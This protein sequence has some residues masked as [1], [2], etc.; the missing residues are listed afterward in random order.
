MVMDESHADPPP[1]TGIG[2]AASP[3]NKEVSDVGRVGAIS[4]ALLLVVLAV[5]LILLVVS[6]WPTEIETTNAYFAVHRI[7]GNSVHLSF[8]ADIVLIT[9]FMGGLGAVIHSLKSLAWHVGESTLMRKWVLYLATLPF[10]G[11]VLS[12]LV[13]LLIR[14]GLVTTSAS[15]SEINPYGMAGIAG[16][17]GLFSEQAAAMLLRVFGTLFAHAPEA[18]NSSPEK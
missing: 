7:L 13:Y 10:V 6:L 9:L 16:L 1:N 4:L 8:D 14:G 3:S 11:A 17:I 5:A 15:A 12:F 18:K 2:D